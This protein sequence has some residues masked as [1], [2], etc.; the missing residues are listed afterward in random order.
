MWGMECARIGWIA[1]PV[2]CREILLMLCQCY[3]HISSKDLEF[4]FL[5]LIL[6]ALHH[7]FILLDALLLLAV[8]LLQLELEVVKISESFQVI[9]IEIMQILL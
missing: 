2:V 6:H 8:V 7:S 1:A 3:L 4:I 5:E 9:P